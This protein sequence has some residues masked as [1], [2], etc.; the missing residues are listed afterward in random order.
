MYEQSNKINNDYPWKR[1]T[2]KTKKI[3]VSVPSGLFTCQQ[4]SLQAHLRANKINTI[5]LSSVEFPHRVMKV[6]ELEQFEL[7]H[8]KMWPLGICEEPKFR[9]PRHGRIQRGSGIQYLTPLAQNFIFIGILD[10]FDKF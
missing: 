1:R 3:R 10:K 8:G 2:H 6:K 4:R 5:C 7:G 9:S